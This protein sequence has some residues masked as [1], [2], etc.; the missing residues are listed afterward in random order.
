[1]I[2]PRC[3]ATG[4]VTPSW[5][6]NASD[7]APPAIATPA[8]R[9]VSA[10]RTRPPTTRPSRTNRT[11]PPARGAQRAVEQAP[12]HAR[13]AAGVARPPDGC[14]RREPVP[15][16]RR[17]DLVEILGL[18]QPAPALTLGDEAPGPLERLELV[19]RHRDDELPAARVTGVVRLLGAKPVDQR[20]V[21]RGRLDGQAEPRLGIA[22]VRLGRED[23]G[24]RV[25]GPADV[26]AVD[27]QGPGAGA[28]QG[29]GRGGGAD[30]A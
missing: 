6:A 1:M 24:A 25:G 28:G 29:V 8:A 7:H 20:R 9:T 15:G 13:A 14:R 17:G 3:G 4:I 11:T 2:C 22:A 16:L 12:T 30:A 10:P 27:E 21:V 18:R 19:L 5:A 26:G 23:A